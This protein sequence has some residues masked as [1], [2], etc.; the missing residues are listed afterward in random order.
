MQERDRKKERDFRL[1]GS[2]YTTHIHTHT[3]VLLLW[4]FGFHPVI[5]YTSKSP[6]LAILFSPDNS[7]AHT[8]MKAQSRRLLSKATREL[9]R[10]EITVLYQHGIDKNK[11]EWVFGAAYDNNIHRVSF[12]V[13]QREKHWVYGPARSVSFCITLLN[14]LMRV[15]KKRKK[16]QDEN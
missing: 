4:M 5:L 10:K 13:I 7:C 11:K 12:C 9:H 6:R 2:P 3:A 15:N 16:K 1:K 8:S 14:N